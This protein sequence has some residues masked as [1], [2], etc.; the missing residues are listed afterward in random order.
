MKTLVDR[1]YVEKQ[2]R[3]LIPTITGD[4]VS[5][6]LET[7]FS[8]YISDSFTAEMEDELDD[9]ARGDR[10]YEP[11]LRAFYTPF[12]KA[13]K[14]KEKVEKVTNLGKAPK[15][16]PCPLCGSSMHYKLG[17]GGTFMSCDRFPEC[18]GT[19]NENGEE[20]KEV[21]PIGKHPETD[22]PIFVKTGRF[23]PYVELGIQEKGSKKKTKK[24]TIPQGVDPKTVTI[25]DAVKFLSLPREL[26]PHP[27]TGEMISAGIGRFGPFIVHQKDF[28]SLKEDDVY[29]IAL[30]RALEIFKEPKKGRK[31][32]EVHREVGPHPKTKKPVMLYKSKSGIFLKKR[33]QARTPPRRH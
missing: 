27:A 24:G 11:T 15:A 30:P 23:G 32:I 1:E 18:E 16:F 26:G 12:Q 13:V 21:E 6:F 20:I 19:R 7:H 10:E 33:I 9:I 29:T 4:V 3:T 17:R 28:R 25:E 14:E 31:G 8:E 2:G 5:T 22:E